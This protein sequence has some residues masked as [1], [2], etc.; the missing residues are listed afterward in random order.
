MHLVRPQSKKKKKDKLSS[1]INMMNL[2]T[3]QDKSTVLSGFQPEPQSKYSYRHIN[4]NAPLIE[5]VQTWQ[6]LQPCVALNWSKM[7]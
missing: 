1:Y 7:L 4:I 5:P 2:N 3:L 6:S